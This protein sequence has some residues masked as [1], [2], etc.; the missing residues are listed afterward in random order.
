MRCLAADDL[1]AFVQHI[2]QPNVFIP[3]EWEIEELARAAR[4]ANI[5]CMADGIPR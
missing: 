2:S 3:E 5:I 1:E 4:H